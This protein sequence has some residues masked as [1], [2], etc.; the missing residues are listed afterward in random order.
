[1]GNSN[2][3]RQQ[4]DN[5]Q[6]SIITGPLAVRKGE[7][8]ERPEFKNVIT[9]IKHKSTPEEVEAAIIRA[10][11]LLS[12]IQPLLPDYTT[13]SRGWGNKKIPGIEYLQTEP[14]IALAGELESRLSMSGKTLRENQTKLN[15]KIKTVDLLSKRVFDRFSRTHIDFAAFEAACK[16]IPTMISKIAEVKGR[17]ALTLSQLAHIENNFSD[18]FNFDSM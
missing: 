11:T 1:M 7:Q 4:P 17:L 8:E 5:Y 14:L 6:D 10:W 18:L 2:S 9:I 12:K 3:P 15:A 16:T 13:P